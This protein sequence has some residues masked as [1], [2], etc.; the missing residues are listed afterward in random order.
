MFSPLLQF[1]LLIPLL[2]PQLP[3]C[4]TFMPQ[5]ISYLLMEWREDAF[6]DM[7]HPVCIE[8]SDPAMMTDIIF[9]VDRFCAVIIDKIKLIPSRHQRISIIK[10]N[11]TPFAVDAHK[12]YDRHKWGVRY[13]WNGQVLY[14][15]IGTPYGHPLNTINKSSAIDCKGFKL[16][17]EGG[18]G[19]RRQREKNM[20]LH[21]DYVMKNLYCKTHSLS[22][23][24]ELLLL[25]GN[26]PVL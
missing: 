5:F 9:S 26:L 12:E 16:G 7:L 11:V 13:D 22:L 10:R 20:I 24:Y 4:G 3:H 23:V 2:P 6:A 18:N 15:I 25:W 17:G 8:I 1:L 19:S 14:R 21:L